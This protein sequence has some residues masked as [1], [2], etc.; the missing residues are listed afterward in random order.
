MLTEFPLADVGPQDIAAAPDGSV[1][2][3]QTTKGNAARITD[4]GTI[5]ETKVVKDS[6]PFGITVDPEGDP[7]YTMLA[8]DKIAEFQLR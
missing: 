2:F 8:A 1:W 4:D 3:T 7:W 6:Q 5:T